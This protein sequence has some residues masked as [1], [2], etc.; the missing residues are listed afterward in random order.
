[1]LTSTES[2]K[3]IRG[4]VTGIHFWIAECRGLS[5]PPKGRE[6]LELE[7]RLTLIW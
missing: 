5:R 4:S 2:E 6:G 7:K 1:M 3:V